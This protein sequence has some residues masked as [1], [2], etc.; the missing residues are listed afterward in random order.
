MH[1][2]SLPWLAAAT[3][4]ALSLAN[5]LQ[6][7]LL[8]QP[9]VPQSDT[10]TFTRSHPASFNTSVS[11]S[12]YS[13][14]VWRPF[15]NP[16]LPPAMLYPLEDIRLRSVPAK[17]WRPRAPGGSARYEAARQANR[18]ASRGF[19]VADLEPLEWDEVDVEAPDVSDMDTL[20]GLAKMTSNAYVEG[21][22]SRK[23]NSGWYHMPDW[24]LGQSFGWTED[25]IRG[26]VFATKD[27]STV[28]VAIKGTSAGLVGGGGSTSGNDKINDNLFFS[29]W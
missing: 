17:V 26:H 22:R 12:G 3:A 28:V 7:P 16:I 9:E 18:W 2:V 29:C 25:G 8:P 15:P 1:P 13:S 23:N 27:N 10:K 21:D 5:A 4:A 11:P 24:D 20:A 19:D 14:A 6:I